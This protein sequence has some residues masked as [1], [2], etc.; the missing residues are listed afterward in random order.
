M[1]SLLFY[2][3]I[4]SRLKI[5]LRLLWVNR[6]VDVTCNSLLLGFASVKAI[7]SLLPQQSLSQEELISLKGYGLKD[8]KMIAVLPILVQSFISICVCV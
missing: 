6:N 1:T 5:S 7:Y 8:S 3:F 4:F 2:I